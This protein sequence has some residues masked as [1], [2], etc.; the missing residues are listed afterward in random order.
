MTKDI[1]VK[2]VADYVHFTPEYFY[3]LFKKEM[4]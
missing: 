3:K 1:S 2:D 4:G